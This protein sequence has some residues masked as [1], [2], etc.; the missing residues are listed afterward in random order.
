MTSDNGWFSA[1]LVFALL[2]LVSPLASHAQTSE[3]G[4]PETVDARPDGAAPEASPAPAP[5]G[6]GEAKPADASEPTEQNSPSQDK[7][8]ETQPEVTGATDTP[9]ATDAKPADDKPADDKTVEQKPLEDKPAEPAALAPAAAPASAPAAP[10]SQPVA[11]PEE[12]KDV[13]LVV[14]SW[15][16]GYGQA[17]ERALFRPFTTDTGHKIELA[18]NGGGA[19]KDLEAQKDQGAGGKPV[20]DLVSL[21]GDVAAKACDAGLLRRLDA[22]AIFGEANAAAVRDDFIPGS[23]QPCAIASTVWSTV[24]L[25]NKPAFSKGAPATV[26]DL[27]D[28]AKFPGKRALPKGGKYVLELALI[29]DGVEAGKVYETLATEDGVARALA[30]LGQLKNDIVWW[31]RGQ[32]PLKLLASNKV[33]MAVAYNGQAFTAAAGR[34]DSLG[35]VWDG[36]IY[37]FDLWAIPQ[38]AK[39]PRTAREFINYASAP[40]RMAAQTKWFAYGPARLSALAKVGKHA[41]LDLDMAPYLPT[42]RD[43][44]KNTLAFNGQWWTEHGSMVSERLDGWMKTASVQPAAAPAAAKDDGDKKDEKGKDKEKDKSKSKSKSRRHERSA[45]KNRDNSEAAPANRE[46]GRRANRQTDRNSPSDGSGADR[47]KPERGQ[48]QGRWSYPRDYMD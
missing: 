41:E 36:Q 14:A 20:W 4:K 15:G 46:G 40:E 39:H 17:Q 33:S 27:F 29:A 9:Q 13:A 42:S 26:Q 25:F 3:G 2:S 21:G 5:E 30:K 32:E 24:I 16:G 31:E 34:R 10:A 6:S 18:A 19:L 44:F 43:N 7:P 28:V 12:P 22:T 8:A 48:G 47:Q 35:F 37:H 23:I 45:D 11:E 38:N 1:A